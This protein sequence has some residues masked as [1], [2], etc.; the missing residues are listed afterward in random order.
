MVI[1]L[2]LVWIYQP[3]RYYFFNDTWDILYGLL[4]NWKSILRPHNEYFLPL[5][6]GFLLVEYKVFGAFHLPYMLVAL[7]LHAANAV[8]VYVLA[9]SLSLRW[10]VSLVAAVLFA[11][12]A[13]PWEITATSLGPCVTLATFFMLLAIYLFRER[14]NRGATLASVAA[15]SLAAFWV[16]GPPPIWLPVVL[17]LIYFQASPQQ[18]DGKS[19]AATLFVIWTP[20]IIYF[21]SLRAVTT[22]SAILS[23]HH[24]RL[25]LASI[26]GMLEYTWVGA[27]FGLLSPSLTG[28][29]GYSV[30]TNLVNAALFVLFLALSYWRLSAGTARKDFWFLVAF[31]LLPYPVISLGRLQLG[32]SLAAGSRYQYVPLAG[33]AL[34]TALCFSSLHGSLRTAR[35]RNSLAAA[36]LVLL[37]YHVVTHAR[38]IRDGTPAAD[39][40]LSAQSFL[41]SAKQATY[42]VTSQLGAKVVGP[43]M[44]VPESLHPSPTMPLWRVLQVLEGT[45]E[46]VVPAGDYL[47][48]RD[49]SL[50][51]NLVRNG[52]FENPLDQDWTA[53]P[54][55]T[56][57]RSAAASH[58]GSFGAAILLS[59]DG[60]AVRREI[61]NTCPQSLPGRI[62]TFSIQV[63]TGGPGVIFSRIVFKNQ[64]NSVLARTTSPAHSL[65]KQWDLAVVSAWSPEEACAVEVEVANGTST[66]MAAFLDDAIA[67]LHPASVP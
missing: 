13:V 61:M 28:R 6:K 12:S 50:P 17:S 54:D 55:E 67:I 59:P 66:A 24:T 38:V 45:T 10:R 3:A 2:A 19:R 63:R 46:T 57:E 23:T 8:L 65:E 7:A 39:W 18:I 20:L 26:P 41:R 15:L 30:S 33:F 37:T 62:W 48:G 22:F 9:K 52:G 40:G 56:F 5:F 21:L 16:G 42:P 4:V 34:L 35:T 11:F 53:G 31:T 29:Q 27:I 36:G 64:S 51:G 60:S 49:A 14:P 47:R 43:E 32:L 1:W 58:T 44:P 25:S